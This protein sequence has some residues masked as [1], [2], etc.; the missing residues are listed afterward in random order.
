[1]RTLKRSFDK[2]RMPPHMIRGSGA[3]KRP[4][5]PLHDDGPGLPAGNREQGGAG[6]ACRR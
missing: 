4:D 6:W 3:T 2:N 1:M 5:P